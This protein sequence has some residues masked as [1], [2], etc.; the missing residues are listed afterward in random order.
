MI[1][2]ECVQSSLLY[3]MMND[4]HP[5]FIQHKNDVSIHYL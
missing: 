3:Y 4:E 1:L 2:D 5:P